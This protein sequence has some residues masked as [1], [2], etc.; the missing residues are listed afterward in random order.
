VAARVEAILAV[1]GGSPLF[2]YLAH[3]YL[4]GLIGLALGPS[5]TGIPRMYPF[6][7][8]GLA[9]LYPLCWLYGRF[10]HGRGPDSLWRL[11]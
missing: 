4:Y 9:I 2:F 1:F 5:G 7:L 10:K 3:L 11:L 8:L 6:W